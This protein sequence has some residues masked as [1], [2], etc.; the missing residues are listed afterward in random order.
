MNMFD[1]G[2]LGSSFQAF[3]HA[4][5]AFASDL[6]NI[7]WGYLI[8]GLLLALAVNLARGHAWANAL[9][10]AYPGTRVREVRGL[11]HEATVRLLPKASDEPEAAHPS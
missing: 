8:A 9:R 7:G 11:L 5:S 2:D 6:A 4:V 1:P 3:G 10:A